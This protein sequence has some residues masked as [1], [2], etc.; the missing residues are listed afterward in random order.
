[1]KVK[2][3]R[4]YHTHSVVYVIRNRDFKLL[5]EIGADDQTKKFNE[6]L[7]NMNVISVAFHRGMTVIS[8]EEESDVYPSQNQKE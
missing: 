5:Q 1:M 8:V 6:S 4:V 7:L 3:V 2:D